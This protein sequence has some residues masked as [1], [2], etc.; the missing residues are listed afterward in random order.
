MVTIL[1]RLVLLGLVLVAPVTSCQ[2]P[3]QTTLTVRT[4]VL[5]QAKVTTMAM[6]SSTSGR[7][8]P[9]PQFAKDWPWLSDGHLGEMVFT[10]RASKDE[11]WTFRVV[12]GVGRDP[13]Q[14]TDS[15]SKGC[16]VA[17]R[18]LSFVPHTRLRVP[19]VLWLACKGVV[20]P[21]DETCD[22]VGKC[23][24]AS[25]DP[26]ACSGPEG[27]T[28]PGDE[29]F[30]GV[31]DAGPVAQVIASADHTCA[32]FSTGK[33]KCWGKNGYGQLGFGDIRHRGDDPGEMGA[34]LPRAD[35]GPDRTAREITTGNDHTCARLDAGTLPC[36][37]YNGDGQLGLGDNRH[38]GG[39][40]FEMGSN[41]PAVD[42]GP[43]RTALQITAGSF[44]TCARLD[45]FSVKCWGQNNFGQLGLGDTMNRGDHSGEMGS[46]LSAVDLGPGR[47]A[48]QI[49]AGSFHTCARLDDG[50]AKCWGRNQLGQLGLGD[51]T[52][53]GDKAGQMGKNLPAVDLGPDRTAL[54]VTAGYQHTCALLDDG[55]VKCWGQNNLGQLGLGD[56]MN[57]GDNP[58]KMGSKLPAVDLGPDHTALELTAGSFHTCARLDGGTVKCWGQNDAGQLGLGDTTNRGDQAGQ[59]GKS[60]P[61]VD[62][63]RGRTALELT[64]GGDHTCARLDDNT[65]KCWGQNNLGQ[66][67][68]GDMKNRGDQAGQMGA[69][70]PALLLQ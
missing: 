10:P 45:N 6:W 7:V 68:L 35:L 63:G 52:N 34:N 16:I 60:L 29:T 65:I 2:E 64:A 39:N 23:V 31:T 22:H 59:M 57:R 69:N 18:K 58:F 53:R 8:A 27:C 42:L 26:D 5:Y 19:V 25:V 44:H 3:T 51:T 55:R 28:L 48:L 24:S 32:R 11:S 66:L 21:E 38:R 56:T 50:T 4:N 30:R 14:C 54:Q 1:R 13:A 70:L 67:G 46:N 40:P 62:L 47:T 37:G 20:C 33:V 17:R 61:T 36:W 43:G 41:L 49:T 15:D 9:E 12:L